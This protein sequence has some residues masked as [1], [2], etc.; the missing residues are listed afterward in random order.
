M[1]AKLHE[2]ELR[3]AHLEAHIAGLQARPSSPVNATTLVAPVQI[4]NRDGQLLAQLDHNHS[5]INLH[6]FNQHGVAGVS[7]GIDEAHAGYLAIRNADGMLVASIDVESWG[8]R[9]QIEDHTRRG[10]VFLFGGDGGE[11]AGGGIQVHHTAGGIS[12]GLWS[13][14]AGGEIT[15]YDGQPKET[16]LTTIPLTVEKS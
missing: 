16:V 7:I 8:A 10:G 3:I 12:L 6:L 15:V 4:V 13:T 11:G 2:L 9:L 5:S 14:Q 1:N